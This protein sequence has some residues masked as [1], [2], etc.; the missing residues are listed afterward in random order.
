LVRPRRPGSGSQ[1]YGSRRFNDRRGVI[2]NNGLGLYDNCSPSDTHILSRN[3]RA[4]NIVRITEFGYV[5]GVICKVN[6]L[7]DPNRAGG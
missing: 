3:P 7:A 4:L 5:A 6:T 1:E 2:H